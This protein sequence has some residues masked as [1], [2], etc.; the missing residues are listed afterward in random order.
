[1]PH[2]FPVSQVMIVLK[3]IFDRLRGHTYPKNKVATLGPRINLYSMLLV[4]L[5]KGTVAAF[6]FVSRI[7]A[8]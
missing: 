1:M 5:D 7:K 4:L 8:I 3:W 2:Y 6:K